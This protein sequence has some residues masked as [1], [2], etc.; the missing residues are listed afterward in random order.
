MVDFKTRI[1]NEDDG[2]II[3]AEVLVYS[4]NGNKIGT[5]DIADATTLNE[6]KQ[7]LQLID[8]T[9]FTEERLK[10]ILANQYEDTSINATKLNGFVSSEFAKV[11]QLN[12]YALSNHTHVKANI[13]NLYD[14]GI[15]A[16]NYNP[17]IDTDINIIVT[18]RDS[19]GNLAI[20]QPVEIL[21]NNESWKIGT[22][23]SLGQ[24]VATYNCSEWGL[25][26]FSANTKSCQVHVSG[27]R[28]TYG[29]SSSTWSLR[30]N[31]DT[32]Q[33]LLK[34]YKKGST[35]TT[36]W[37]PFGGGQAYAEGIAPPTYKV[38]LNSGGD[39]YMRA[40]RDGTFSMKAIS[41]SISSTTDLY[42]LLEW[43][44]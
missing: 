33:L 28:Y 2:Q 27:W 3:G 40:H 35:I 17:N 25:V 39:L 4:D 5:I 12:N 16:T 34:G 24:F 41:G 9:Y 42:C 15:T 30:R 22:T 11:S 32:A 38:A 14:Y 44:F 19:R 10:S 18:V 1:F 31:K 13:T 7:Q 26:T 21:K 37:E 23:N 20:G 36:S 43:N 29:T 8:E 6:L